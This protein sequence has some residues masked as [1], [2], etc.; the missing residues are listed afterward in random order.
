MFSC[1]SVRFIS[2][3]DLHFLNVYACGFSKITTAINYKSYMLYLGNVLIYDRHRER[4]TFSK[5]VIDFLHI[6]TL[7]SK[8]FVRYFCALYGVLS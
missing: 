7:R 6:F 1:W 4:K 2:Y 8:Y 5:L 3:P